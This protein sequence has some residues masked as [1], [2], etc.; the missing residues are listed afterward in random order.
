MPHPNW[1]IPLKSR[2]FDRVALPNANGCM[3]W[4]GGVGGVEPRVYGRFRVG[5]RTVLAHR[6]SYELLVEPI[7]SDLQ[8]DHTCVVT[9]CVTPDHLE[10][11][12]AQINSLRSGN[13][14]GV[15][16]RKT[17]CPELHPYSPENTFHR[18]GRRLCKIC[19]RAEWRRWYLSTRGHNG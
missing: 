13:L 3:L 17:H 16:A 15:N 18:N 9:L 2:F 5:K 1:R 8:I 10:P 14:A 7:P 4:L 12:T 19:K 11:V 6:F